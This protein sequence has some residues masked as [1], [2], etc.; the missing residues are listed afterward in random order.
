[1]MPA[2]NGI[3]I[4]LR[5]K[6]RTLLFTL[7]IFVL[8]VALTLGVGMWA[9]CAQLLTRFN[10]TYTSIVLAEYMG[11][12]YPDGNA[13][14]ELARE[15]LS[16]LDDNAIAAVDGVELWERTDSTLVNLAG[17]KLAGRDVPYSSYGVI[18]V[19][20]LFNTDNGYAGRID[21]VLYTREGK[22][23]II[24]L[25]DFSDTDLEAS[26]GDGKKYLM[27]GKFVNVNNCVFS[28]ATV[29]IFYL[30]PQA[31][32]YGTVCVIFIFTF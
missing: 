11:E 14:D 17:Y 4:T 18:V 27:H 6:G 23:H 16:A 21:K 8:T 10:E 31:G 2:R 30:I 12:D 22:E 15:A 25:F 28:I 5:A 20:G 26:P 19:S 13:A 9:Y 3:L 29:Y 24:S 1:M 32:C 7:L